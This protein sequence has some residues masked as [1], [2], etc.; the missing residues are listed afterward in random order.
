MDDPRH[1]PW[2]VLD[3]I[4]TDLTRYA[5]LFFDD[6]LHTV[7]IGCVIVDRVTVPPKYRGNS[8]GVLLVAEALTVLGFGRSVAACDPA[9]FELGFDDP[10]RIIEQDRLEWLWRSFGFSPHESRVW[11]LDLDLITLGETR[12]A[13]RRRV[14]TRLADTT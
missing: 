2:H 5:S 1:E 14:Q 11:V 4:N 12:E 7:F 3:A 6:D 13:L 10:T 9:P 8:L